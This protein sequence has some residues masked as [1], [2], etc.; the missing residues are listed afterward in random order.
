VA[1][2]IPLLITDFFK[3]TGKIEHIGVILKK[4]KTFW[5]K[6]KIPQNSRAKLKTIGKNSMS[7]RTCPLPPSQVV[8]K[9]MP[10]PSTHRSRSRSRPSR[11]VHL[12]PENQ[13]GLRK[14][15]FVYSGFGMHDNGLLSKCSLV[16]IYF[17]TG[18]KTICRN[19]IHTIVKKTKSRV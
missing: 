8:L 18:Q 3:K 1:L 14:T 13:H 10:C 4:N 9:K 15:Y 2:F 19:F 7:R 12:K 5:T 16:F 11:Q 17:L 6:K